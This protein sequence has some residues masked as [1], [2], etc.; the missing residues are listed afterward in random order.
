M[1][2]GRGRMARYIV[3]A[4]KETANPLHRQIP[5]TRENLRSSV[6]RDWIKQQDPTFVP[7]ADD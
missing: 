2:A 4:M 1:V 6:I 5:L 3:P 7:M